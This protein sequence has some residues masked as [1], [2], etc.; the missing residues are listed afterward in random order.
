MAVHN[1][2]DP[3]RRE[4]R[5]VRLR[6]PRAPSNLSLELRTV[7]LDDE[8]A[9]Y[10]AL[11]YVWGSSSGPQQIEINGQPFCVTQN[12]HDALQQLSR[13]GVD[14]W[15]WIDAICIQ[16]S[17]LE[18]KTHQVGMMRDIFSNAAIVYI[19]LGPGT[20]ETDQAM[21]LISKY[22]PRLYACNALDLPFNGEN[23][24]S[25][26]KFV[27]GRLDP[28]DQG[29]VELGPATELAA[30]AVGLY[31]EY[32]E[33]NKVLVRGVSDIL[34]R[35]YWVRIWIIQEV[36]LAREAV[37]MVGG[38]SVSL[39][40]FDAAFTTM[41]E[42]LE[43]RGILRQGRRE[44]LL[45][46]V[47]WET[48][49]APDRPHYAASDPRDLLIGLLGVL[50]EDEKHGLGS[51]YTQSLGEVFTRATRAMLENSAPTYFNLDSV[52]PGEPAGELPT[53]VP[54][55]REIGRTMRKVPL[56]VEDLSIEGLKFLRGE[57]MWDGEALRSVDPVKAEEMEHLANR[58][59][60]RAYRDMSRKYRT[61]FKTRKGMFGLGHFGIASGD[62]VTLMWGVGS[63]IIL[64]PR[65][66]G[67]YYFRGDSYVDGI[68]QGEFL[69][70]QPR[71]QELIIH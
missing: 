59:R 11:S 70:T 6:Q 64:R 67:G 31:T 42:A 1:H 21:D 71:E 47:L 53:W 10:S 50:N 14:S 62:V 39:D 25:L 35:S 34:H 33:N 22:G 3:D 12:L 8:E 54:D 29:T 60:G 30:T 68:M 48:G 2:L 15:L 63:P 36:A 43:V 49:A 56:D 20:E 18:E 58:L 28:G 27:L 4:I 69:E 23:T 51:D 61:L 44:P 45:R 32:H 41:W 55:F 38:R 9:S 26:R 57:G 66:E 16:Q 13:D 19:W 24:S 17:D 37:A 40:A 52:K 46:R 65:D 7:S 5:L